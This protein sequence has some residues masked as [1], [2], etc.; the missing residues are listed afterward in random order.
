MGGW[1]GGWGVGGW[2]WWCSFVCAV[3]RVPSQSIHFSISFVIVCSIAFDLFFDFVLLLDVMFE[4]VCV[5]VFGFGL[6]LDTMPELIIIF[7]VVFDSQFQ[8]SCS[9]SFLGRFRFRFRF[10]VHFHFILRFRV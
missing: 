2:W 3:R 1:V 6:V 10:H 8:I 5:L 9:F 4:F 7:C